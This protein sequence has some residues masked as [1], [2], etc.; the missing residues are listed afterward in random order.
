MFIAAIVIPFASGTGA[1]AKGLALDFVAPED[2]ADALSGI[3]LIEKVGEYI[4]LLI[5]FSRPHGSKRVSSSNLDDCDFW[6][7]FCR[8]QRNRTRRVRFYRE[9]SECTTCVMSQ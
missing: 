1:A 2:R 7:C 4:N 6:L 9:R 5:P 3:A 8:L